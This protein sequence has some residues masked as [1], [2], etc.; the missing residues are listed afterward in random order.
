MIYE[1]IIDTLLDS[2]KMLPF[3][4]GTYFFIE[5]LE[6]LASDGFIRKLRAAGRFGSVAGAVLGLIPQCG[7]SVAAVGL[8]HAGVVTLGALLAVLLSTSDEAL[9]VLLANPGSWGDIWRLLLCKLVVASLAGIAVDLLGIDRRGAGDAGQEAGEDKHHYDTCHCRAEES[10][11]KSVLRHTAGTFFFILVVTLAINLMIATIGEDK[12]SVL[13]LTNTVWQPLLSALVGFI[14]SCAASVAL[15]QLYVAGGI[16][17]GGALAGLCTSGG[18]GLAVLYKS[19][20]GK[21]TLKIC[22]LLYVIGAASGFA[23]NALF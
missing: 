7:I 19:R 16:S 22:A 4:L 1:V 18:V 5:W 20:D 8:Y 13:L 21:N 9:P 10:L 11:L 23:A 6:H 3:L 14:P 2:V 15:T 17:F 12:L